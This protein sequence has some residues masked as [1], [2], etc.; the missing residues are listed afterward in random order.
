MNAE[1]EFSGAGN[2]TRI[3]V[4]RIRGSESDRNSFR[5]CEVWPG[6]TVVNTFRSNPT[7]LLKKSVAQLVECYTGDQRVACVKSPCVVSFQKQDILSAAALVLVQ[8]MSYEDNLQST[9]LL[10]ELCTQ[11]FFYKGKI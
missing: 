10:A 6:H 8:L 7:L 4:T 3:I 2:E 9:R 11:V 5:F 1:I